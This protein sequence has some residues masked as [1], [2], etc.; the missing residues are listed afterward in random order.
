MTLA[1]YMKRFAVTDEDLARQIQGQGIPCHRTTVLRLRLGTIW[2][3]SAEM[4]RTIQKITGGRVT[5]NDFVK[6]GRI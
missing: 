3:G 4:A 6:A 2:L 1:Q 5:A